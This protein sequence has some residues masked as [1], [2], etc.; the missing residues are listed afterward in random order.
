MTALD[1]HRM[2]HQLDEATARRLIERLEN[3]AKDA[4]FTRLFD[5]YIGRLRFPAGA[6]ILEIGCGTGAMTRALARKAHFSGTVTGVDQSPLFIEAAERFVAD[7]GLGDRV[8]FNVGDAHALD[9]ETESTDAVIA[10]TVL[11]HVTDPMAVLKEM[12][13]IARPGATLVIFDGDYGSLT[14]GHPDADLGRRMDHA[15]ATATFN[16]PL[17]MRG[18]ADLCQDLGLEITETLANVVAEIGT[19]SY[20]KTFAETYAPLVTSGGLLPDAQVDGWLADQRAAMEAGTFFAS[21]NYYTYLL[22]RG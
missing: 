13:R 1:P 19:A 10:H 16:N 17:I 2:S 7:E 5:Q 8:E 20:F 21:C 9:L 22:R 18:L 14:Y 15:L 3:R 4:V 6:R 12:A 11:S